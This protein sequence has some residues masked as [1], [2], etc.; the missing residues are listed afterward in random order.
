MALAICAA[1]AVF[2]E[3]DLVVGRVLL[4]LVVEVVGVAADGAVTG[5][6]FRNIIQPESRSHAHQH[7]RVICVL[8]EG[9]GG[10]LGAGDKLLLSPDAL[11]MTTDVFL[12]GSYR[13][14]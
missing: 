2:S 9:M 3:E 1:V 12:N 8:R 11:A 6:R 13:D 10:E 7:E 14:R 4:P 5:L